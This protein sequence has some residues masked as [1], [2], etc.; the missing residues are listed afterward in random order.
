MRQIDV[1]LSTTLK[2]NYL[3]TMV[4]ETQKPRNLTALP[5]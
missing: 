1:V 2:M 5:Y 4:S 3:A